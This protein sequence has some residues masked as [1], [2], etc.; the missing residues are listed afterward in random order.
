MSEMPESWWL[1][2]WSN[3]ERKYGLGEDMAMTI[4]VLAAC[5]ACVAVAIAAHVMMKN[6]G[7]TLSLRSAASR[8]FGLVW[9]VPVVAVLLFLAA[10]IVLYFGQSSNPKSP[11]RSNEVKTVDSSGE[12]KSLKVEVSTGGGT[13]VEVSASRSES[14][15][16]PAAAKAERTEDSP[17]GSEPPEWVD[18]GEID[19]ESGRLVVVNS[20]QF[21]EKQ[22]AEQDA[23]E[24]AV[25]VVRAD[26]GESYNVRGNWSLAPDLVRERAV[27]ETWF[28]R[29]SRSTGQ[30][31]FYVYRA[32][33][34][35]ELSPE[36]R[37][38]VWT[39][40]RDQVVSRRLWILGGL[41]GFVTL[42]LGTA[43][44]YLRLDAVTGG[45]YRRRL[46][47]AS[48]SLLVA[49]GLALAVLLPVA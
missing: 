18:G 33:Q 21:P 23:L 41:L 45:N 27:K 14:T 7:R 29:I 46:K 5:L 22:L 10:P 15:E 30:N 36:V 34:Q 47:L 44:T 9:L 12:V 20:E 4:I 3:T 1:A 43:A 25:R 42:M 49:G 26:F 11:P 28:E 37:Q 40:W 32:Y 2:V 16:P 48:V 24:E 6:G 13:S 35:V 38:A 8:L 19:T 39:S 31:R 17:F